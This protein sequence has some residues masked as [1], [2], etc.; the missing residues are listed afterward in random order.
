MSRFFSIVSALTLSTSLLVAQGSKLVVT[1]GPPP[2]SPLISKIPNGSVWKVT[3]HYKSD[4]TPTDKTNVPSSQE[5]RGVAAN[6]TNAE[7]KPRWIRYHIANGTLLEESEDT[8]GKKHIR[9][10]GK[11]F[12]VY[13]FD[14]RMIVEPVD[15]YFGEKTFHPAEFEELSWIKPGTYVGDAVYREIPCM[16]FQDLPATSGNKTYSP[17]A[18]RTAFV[19]KRTR[20]PIEVKDGSV[21]R[22]YLFEAN[23]PNMKLPAEVSKAISEHL[24]AKEKRLRKYRI[25][26]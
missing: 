22:T 25:A 5:M 23:Q 20:L 18:Y 24:T 13:T 14:N 8:D 3:Y 11:D 10:I 17:K 15:A 2:Q 12:A 1:P 4:V 19:D 26:Q 21:S 16:V 9:Y 6:G 7:G